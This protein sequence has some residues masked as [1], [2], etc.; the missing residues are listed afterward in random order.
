MNETNNTNAGTDNI[1][2]NPNNPLV[3]INNIPGHTFSDILN[4]SED[5]RSITDDNGK[6]IQIECVDG[7]INREAVSSSL[8]TRT[9]VNFIKK[10]ASFNAEDYVGSGFSDRVCKSNGV[11]HSVIEFK[12][13]QT[14]SSNLLKGVDKAFGQCNDYLRDYK[15]GKFKS[16]GVCFLTVIVMD[17]DKLIDNPSLIDL[18][19][20]S[21]DIKIKSSALSSIKE[22]GIFI[23]TRKFDTDK[24]EYV[25]VDGAIYQSHVIATTE[26]FKS[27]S[28]STKDKLVE[29]IA[30]NG[31]TSWSQPCFES[32]NLITGSAS[33][34]ATNVRERL[35]LSNV[36]KKALVLSMCETLWSNSGLAGSTRDVNILSKASGVKRFVAIF[37]DSVIHK[38]LREEHDG[39]HHIELTITS[40][41]AALIDGQQST[42]VP[43]IINRLL[44][45][46][47]KLDTTEKS[48]KKD[49]L[50]IIDSN[51]ARDTSKFMEFIKEC[52]FNFTVTIDNDKQINEFC[53]SNNSSISQDPEDIIFTNHDNQ[54]KH[55]SGEI[56]KNSIYLAT[57]PNCSQA[58]TEEENKIDIRQVVTAQL[59]IEK[60]LNNEK[61]ASGFDLFGQGRG[62][63]YKISNKKTKKAVLGFMK[64]VKDASIQKNDPESLAKEK[65]AKNDIKAGGKVIKRLKVDIESLMD[66]VNDF[67]GE[68]GD[69]ILGMVDLKYVE[70]AEATKNIESAERRKKKAVTTLTGG[71]VVKKDVVDKL[72]SSI[73]LWKLI[74]VNIDKYS[75]LTKSCLFNKTKSISIILF[76]L[77]NEFGEEIYNMRGKKMLEKYIIK[78][79]DGFI[80][81][82]EDYDFTWT[83]VGNNINAEEAKKLSIKRKDDNTITHNIFDLIDGIGK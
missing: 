28:Y 42:E 20:N 76:F 82:N 16:T 33:M 29:N 10:K 59:A 62:H 61:S 80:S 81:L 38:D 31:T 34:S 67:G 77:V 75:F 30:I 70:I 7:S 43:F 32:Y 14:I 17:L 2:T 52:P 74:G 45:P 68:N 37:N 1:S 54:F 47:S 24:K 5:L 49:I 55:L 35:P 9:N 25:F 22:Y 40:A 44:D 83:M 65:Q 69:K 15:S 41:N 53:V 36:D 27:S 4:I 3:K 58:S 8:F 51:S 63:S 71:F 72:I 73:A 79:I 50:D 11:C 60:A 6:V 26:T 19:T 78:I 39:T 21:T 57:Y 56:A 18:Y 23:S 46:K 12:D 13:Y 64:E 48:I 66:L